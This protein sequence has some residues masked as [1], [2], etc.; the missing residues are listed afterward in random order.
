[1]VKRYNK[2]THSGH[3]SPLTSTPLST[4]QESTSPSTV[5]ARPPS[6]NENQSLSLN[7]DPKNPLQPY[8]D[9]PKPIIPPR[10]VGD[11]P[12]Q[13][14]RFETLNHGVQLSNP[15]SEGDPLL[16][17]SVVSDSN[18]FLPS[19]SI[20]SSESNR[21]SNDDKE[22]NDSKTMEKQTDV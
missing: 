8:V 15:K 17:I 18:A 16:P 9:E 7:L 22:P 19:S 11:H 6:D 4:T 12:K 20:S 2:L 10:G 1:M 5:A 14:N 3:P 21:L 13:A